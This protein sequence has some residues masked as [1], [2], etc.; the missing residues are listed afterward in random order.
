MFGDVPTAVLVAGKRW[1]GRRP[2][3]LL[4]TL[5]SLLEPETDD[6]LLCRL[7]TARCGVGD[8]EKFLSRW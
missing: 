3:G 2:T 7:T 6:A 8:L 4:L 1:T 5:R